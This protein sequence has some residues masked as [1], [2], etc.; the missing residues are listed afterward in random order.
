M[1]AQKAEKS[2][3]STEEATQEENKSEKIDIKY[4]S[5][6]FSLPANQSMRSDNE[7]SDRTPL[8]SIRRS[9]SNNFLQKQYCSPQSKRHSLKKA[10]SKPKHNHFAPR[11][12]H[13]LPP[14][15]SPRPASSPLPSSP[16]ICLHPHQTS[17]NTTQT[18]GLSPPLLSV[19]PNPLT[20]CSALASPNAI[21]APLPHSPSPFSTT[22]VNAQPSPCLPSNC[23]INSLAV[24]EQGTKKVFAISDLAA[25]GDASQTLARRT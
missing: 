8:P 12:P 6:M 10:R 23:S 2:S 3:R 9:Q 16:S 19:H 13:L 21:V 7:I 1:T 11:N 14:L 25:Q 24:V 4:H 15:H 17:C 22:S 20:P 5:V 18:G